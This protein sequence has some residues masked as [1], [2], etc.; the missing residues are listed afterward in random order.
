MSSPS[1]DPLMN[2]PPPFSKISLPS[3]TD[4]SKYKNIC[5][6][7]SIVED[8]CTFSQYLNTDTYPVIYSSHGDRKIEHKKKKTNRIKQCFFGYM[9]FHIMK[10]FQVGGAEM[11]FILKKMNVYCVVSIM[12]E[13]A[14]NQRL[15]SP[16]KWKDR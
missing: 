16:K 1:E 5:F 10:G 9:K 7:S 12:N 4:F 13:S 14:L 15:K 11:Y 2:G 6:I 3:S 8:S